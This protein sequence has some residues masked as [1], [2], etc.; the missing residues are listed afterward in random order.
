MLLGW[1]RARDT[2]V[3]QRRLQCCGGRCVGNELPGRAV[4]WDVVVAGAA[5]AETTIQT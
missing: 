3:L 5:T 4:R 2:V 1:R